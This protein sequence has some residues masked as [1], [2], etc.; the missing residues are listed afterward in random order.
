MK[1]EVHDD[2]QRVGA[3]PCQ[4]ICLQTDSFVFE[5][6]PNYVNKKQKQQ[7]PDYRAGQETGLPNFSPT[8]LWNS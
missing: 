8:S 6:N 7:T 1:N 5:L 3:S 2:M 4:Y